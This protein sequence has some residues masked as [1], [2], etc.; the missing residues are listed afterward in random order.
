VKKCPK[1][2]TDNTDLMNFCVECGT[3]LGAAVSNE[4]QTAIFPNPTP[5]NPSHTQETQTVVTNFQQPSQ[6]TFQTPQPTVVTNQPSYTPPPSPNTVGTSG[7]AP[8][9]VQPKKSSKMIWIVGGI[10]VVLILG[11]VGIVHRPFRRTL[12]RFLPITII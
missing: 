5:T 10:A 9:P 7:F 4:P 1:C 3:P 8:A 11:A 12:L 2:N 6:P